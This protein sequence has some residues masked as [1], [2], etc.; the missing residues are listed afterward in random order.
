MSRAVILY[1][2]GILSERMGKRSFC[3]LLLAFVTSLN[4]KSSRAGLI[5]SVS[6]VAILAA[7]TM[8]MECVVGGFV[9]LVK[10]AVVSR[11]LLVAI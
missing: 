9:A 3:V 6:L 2:N 10:L 1:S 8:V 7:A 4:I 5:I 11:R